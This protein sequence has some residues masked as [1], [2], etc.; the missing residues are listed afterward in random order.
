MTFRIVR[1]SDYLLDM[2]K[3]LID[4]YKEDKEMAK[5][6]KLGSGERFSAL[7]DKLER[8]GKSKEAAKGIAAAVGRKK[9][10]NSKMSEMAEKGKARK[11]K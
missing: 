3:V 1:Y 11:A 5:K 6:P 10:G 9:Y 2:A 8:K 7:V 4:F